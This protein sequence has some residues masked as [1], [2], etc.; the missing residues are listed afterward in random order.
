MRYIKQEITGLVRAKILPGSRI[1]DVGCGDGTMLRDL[2]PATG[3]GIDVDERAISVARSSYPQLGF[4]CSSIEDLDAETLEPFDYVVLSGVL[5]QVH[6]VYVVLAQLRSL[7]SDSTRLVVVSYS[8][9]WQ[10][11]VRVAELLRLRK[12]TR[13]ENWIPPNELVNLLE[14]SGFCVVTKTAGVL[15]PINLLFL[16][17]FVNRWLAPL[18]LIRQLAAVTVTVARP[19]VGPNATRISPRVSVVIAARNESGNIRSLVRRLPQLSDDQEVIFVEGHST[20]GT[21][22]QIN[23]VIA[24]QSHHI[25]DTKFRAI[26]Q[27]GIGRGD[28]IRAGLEV[29]TGDILITMCADLSVPPEELPRFIECLRNGVCEFA[30]GS[31]L[32]YPMED[33][34]MQFLNIIGNRIFGIAFTFLLGQQ[35]RDTL[36]GTKVLWARDYRRIVA[37]R[38]YFGDFDPFGDFDLLFGASRL[39]LHIRDVPVHYKARTYGSTKISRFRH[40]LLLLRMT[41]IAARRIRFT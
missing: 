20:D 30:N 6:D 3:M 25:G 39:G 1:L 34:A 26:K 18:P 16:S 40:G 9:L 15:I 21:C 41:V 13:E 2:L 12:R 4:I 5:E 33:K 7:V 38:S 23:M 35:I 19:T 24:E 31:R 36:C 37:N 32:L 11:A 8:R 10:P 29:A 22:E 14:Q 27:P 17:R 28:A